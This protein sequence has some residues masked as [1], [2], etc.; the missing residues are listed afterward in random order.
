MKALDRPCSIESQNN[1]AD[2]SSATFAS[3]V[4]NGPTGGTYLPSFSVV[5]GM[6]EKKEDDGWFLGIKERKKTT[7][8]KYFNDLLVETI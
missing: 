2:C 5:G 7:P 6:T 3:V 4:M 8:F 1:T